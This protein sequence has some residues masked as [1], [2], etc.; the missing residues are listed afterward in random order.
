MVNIENKIIREFNCQECGKLVQV[1]NKRDRRTRNCSNKCMWIGIRNRRKLKYPKEY[2][3]K[4]YVSDIREIKKDL[5]TKNQYYYIEDGKKYRCDKNG[6]VR[7]ILFEDSL[8]SK[9]KTKWT[10]ADCIELV[11]L[12]LSG[13]YKDSDIALERQI[14]SIRNRFYLL[15]KQG[16]IPLYLEKFKKGE[17]N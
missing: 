14:S 1:T 10:K 9:S 16:K 7:R 12:K 4:I 13:L 5:T 8:V 17:Y 2:K 11:G 3:K 6:Y 15:K